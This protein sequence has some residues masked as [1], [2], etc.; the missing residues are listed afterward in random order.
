MTNRD[1][2]GVPNINP[3]DQG[4]YIDSNDNSK[5]ID[6]KVSRLIEQGRRRTDI[7]PTHQ[8]PTCSRLDHSPRFGLGPLRKQTRCSYHK[9]NLRRNANLAI[10]RSDLAMTV[11]LN[12]R[13]QQRTTDMQVKVHGDIAIPKITHLVQFKASGNR[14]N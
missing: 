4:R 8:Q 5:I 10:Q 14:L 3:C 6:G 12:V 9:S 2:C 1:V 13:L 7:E 11:A